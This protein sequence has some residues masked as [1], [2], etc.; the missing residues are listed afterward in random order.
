M[1]DAVELHGDQFGHLTA[2]DILRKGSL[3][4]AGEMR[5]TQH[6]ATVEPRQANP[7][8]RQPHTSLPHSRGNA[9]PALAVA[10]PPRRGHAPVLPADHPATLI[11]H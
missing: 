2:R 7:S 4:Y 10:A 9:V 1:S 8:R 3:G 11:H 6:Y 5:S